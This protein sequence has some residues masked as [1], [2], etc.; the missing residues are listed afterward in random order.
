[1][2]LVNIFFLVQMTVI[3]T[4]TGHPVERF[5]YLFLRPQVIYFILIFS[6]I[7]KLPDSS[8]ACG[9]SSYAL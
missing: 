6:E 1:M 3:S 9:Y 7:V 5:V 8:N 4:F 2:R